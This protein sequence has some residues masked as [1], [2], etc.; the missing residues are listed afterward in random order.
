[1]VQAREGFLE[2]I[3][4][5]PAGYRTTRRDLLKFLS[6]GAAAASGYAVL[7]RAKVIPC[8]SQSNHELCCVGSAE[9]CVCADEVSASAPVTVQLELSSLAADAQ[10]PRLRATLATAAA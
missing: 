6:L 9:A 3:V 5:L 1:M 2:G 4:Q 8:C 7:S 10:L